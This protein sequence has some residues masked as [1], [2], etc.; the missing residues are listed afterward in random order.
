MRPGQV[1]TLSS[2]DHFS[3][4]WMKSLEGKAVKGQKPS[5]KDTHSDDIE[6]QEPQ[7]TGDQDVI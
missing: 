5:K 1:F 4:K 7:G 2:R 3:E 6:E